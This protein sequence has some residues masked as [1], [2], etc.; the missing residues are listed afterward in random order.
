MARGIPGL[1]RYRDRVALLRGLVRYLPAVGATD[2]DLALLLQPDHEPHEAHQQQQQQQEQHQHQ[3]QQQQQQ[4]HQHQH[5]HQHQQD[6]QQ[7]HAHDQRTLGDIPST[8]VSPSPS[9]PASLEARA[10]RLERLMVRLAQAA[11][12]PCLPAGPAG[13]AG[14]AATSVTAGQASGRA[15]PL[16][17]DNPFN[18]DAFVAMALVAGTPLSNPY[19]TPI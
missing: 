10:V 17:A 6:Q 8:A 5:Q 9:E 7:D 2:A 1:P 12:L 16:P 13:P 19:L 4:Q 15:P 3:H 11:A 14:P 18:G